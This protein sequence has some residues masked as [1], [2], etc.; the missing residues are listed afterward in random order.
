MDMNYATNIAIL[1]EDGFVENI[2]WG[3]IYQLDEFNTDYTRAVVFGEYNVCIG[4]QY[5]DGVWYR[6]GELLDLR[7]ERELAD[8]AEAILD[9]LYEGAEVTDE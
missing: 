1:N 9:M 4:D 5:V 2:I 3:M 8:E 6:N 7:T